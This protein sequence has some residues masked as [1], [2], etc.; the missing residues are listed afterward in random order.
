VPESV[1]VP[2]GSEASGVGGPAGQRILDRAVLVTVLSRVL[3]I[4]TAPIGLL[5]TIQFLTDAERG[6]YYTFFSLLG[7]SALLDGG[8]SAT[9]QHFISREAA[10]L[11]VSSDRMLEG[12]ATNV[13]RL[14]GLFRQT[15]RWYLR[16]AV[17]FAILLWLIGGA[18]FLMTARND[19][20]RWEVPWVLCVVAASLSLAASPLIAL[21]TGI[22]RVET[23][24]TSNA[25]RL[26]TSTA[27]LCALLWW[28]AGLYA[29]PISGLFGVIVWLMAIVGRWLPLIRQVSRHKTAAEPIDWSSQ[30]WPMQWRMAV[31]IACG[32][33]IFRAITPIVF[34]TSGAV[35]AGRFGLTQMA[36]DFAA[37]VSSSWLAVRTP[38][39]A[40]LHSLRSTAALESLFRSTFWVGVL[41]YCACIVLG[42]GLLWLLRPLHPKFANAF[43]GTAPFLLLAVWTLTNQVLVLFATYCRT[44]GTEPFMA[45]S[46]ASAIATLLGSMLAGTVAGM[47]GITVWLAVHNAVLFVPWAWLIYRDVRVSTVHGSA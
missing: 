16:A 35:E 6:Y 20:I 7:F 23:I 8:V 25:L 2:A 11:V 13:A 47:T 10:Q 24:A 41:G 37:Q 40:K 12:N 33:F 44:A 38:L 18:F 42:M 14:A 30:I 39:M 43:L 9:V 3:G 15:C 19:G 4:V 46:V 22:G 26:L 28:G 5:F 34:S 45:I 17:V 36:I 31:S 27:A 1:V 21:I 32:F 29:G